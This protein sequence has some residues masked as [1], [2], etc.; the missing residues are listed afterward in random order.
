MKLRVRLFA[1]AAD[2]AGTR[3]LE[4]LLPE[5]CCVGDLRK[6]LGSACPALEP[7]SSALLFAVNTQYATDET[8]LNSTD[9]VACFP[10]VSGG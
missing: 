3:E 9:E 2:R 7:L 1:A 4:L 10:P 5:T 6:A 8:P